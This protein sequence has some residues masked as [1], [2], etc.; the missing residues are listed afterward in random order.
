MQDTWVQSLNLEDPLEKQM[1][2]H[3]SIPA[4]EVPQTEETGLATVH[5]VTKSQT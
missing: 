1:T 3:S 5:G 4:G 2:I